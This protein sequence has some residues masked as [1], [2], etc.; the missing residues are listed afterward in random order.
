MSRSAIVN[1]AIRASA[2]TGKTYQLAMRYIRLL[3]ERCMPD[4]I[5]AMTFSRKAAAEI[6][7]A[8]VQNLR[9]AARDEEGANMIARDIG[10]DG[11]KPKDF[12]GLLRT[13]LD[14]LQLSHISTLDSFTVS[15]IRAFPMEL[16][17]STELN[18]MD[19]DGPA[20]RLVRFQVLSRVFNHRLTGERVQQNFHEAFKEA[21]F[22]RE[23]SDMFRHLDE[24]IRKYWNMFRALP[25]PSA[26]GNAQLIWPSGS[27]WLT[28][29]MKP[30]DAADQLRAIINSRSFQH[31]KIQPGLNQLVDGLAA[32]ELTRPWDQ[33]SAGHAALGQLL[34]IPDLATAGSAT[35][36]YHKEIKLNQKEC[37]LWA[38]L[39]EHFLGVELHR[40]LRETA[41]IAR[42][43]G[44]YR[45]LYE[46]LIR[47]GQMT[48][49]DAQYLLT[50]DNELSGNARVSRNPANRLYIDYRLNCRLD[51]W[52][53]DEFQ[54]T[55]DLQWEVVSNLI[56]EVMMDDSGR[57]RLFFVGDV[58]QAVHGWRGGNAR[59]FGKV[60]KTYE[61][62]IEEQNRIDSYRSCQD[63]LDMVNRVFHE[64]PDNVSA[65]V[66]DRWAGLWA[67]HRVAEGRAPKAGYGA[68]LQA[69][70][71][72]DKGKCLAED[73][74]RVVGQ[75]LKEI[76]PL[77]RGLSVVVLVRR[78]E[79]GKALVDQL[80]RECPNIPICHEGRARICDNPVVTVLL[81]LTKVAAHPGDTLAWQHLQMSPLRKYIQSEKLD[82]GKL[83]RLLLAE[84]Q[85]DGFES[86]I[87]RW[88][89]RLELAG[90]DH[91]GRK[92]VDDLAAAAA[93]FDQGD[94]RSCSDFLH[95]VMGHETEEAGTDA[96]VNVMTV[97]KSK[98]IGRDIVIAAD[99]ESKLHSTVDFALSRNRDMGSAAWA[100]KMPC[101]MVVEAD[102]TLHAAQTRKL[103]EME[104]EELC[105]LYVALTRA[106]RANY[107]VVGSD[108]PAGSL[109]AILKKQLCD[110]T[111]YAPWTFGDETVQCLY[112]TG[113]RNWHEREAVC[114]PKK[115]KQRPVLSMDFHKQDS[116][117]PHLTRREP[118]KL[119]APRRSAVSLFDREDTAVIDFGSAIHELFEKVQWAEDADVD[120]I[121]RA[122][123]PTSTC[124]KDV[125]R[126]AI[127]QFRACMKSD[128]VRKYLSR[129]AGRV[130]E[131]WIEKRFE[132][133][134]KGEL[135]AGAFD[136]VIVARDE[137]GR[138]VSA[139]ILD[140]KSSRVDEKAKIDRKVKEYKSQ[141]DTYR[142]ALARILNL[143]LSAITCCLIF[144]RQQEIRIPEVDKGH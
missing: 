44:E 65:D 91:F 6:L 12:L 15:V 19:N 121:V 98:G 63:V 56:S 13:L 21:T 3:A 58:K 9:K 36:K 137:H 69:T 133:I 32:S 135:V 119:H 136:R 35:I 109:S 81:S 55:S 52:L 51:H 77:R 141:M 105:V 45:A 129:P 114:R 37:R 59:L 61:G 26:W 30:A 73:R 99:L 31:A 86:A 64:L 144:T 79:A 42:I 80:R 41:G 40:R 8:I 138:V 28:P 20:A 39:I 71:T 143:K 100:L 24:F 66:R 22:G 7:D 117:R 93:V 126:D 102:D 16:G 34:E 89:A 33:K 107:A 48:F 4:Q 5:C 23:E 131:P 72:G 11:L 104:F 27:R 62:R 97:H 120:S 75:L 94:S 130:D 14:N 108:S 2:G 139:T 140:Y 84:I 29:S 74:Y 82:P 118:S 83:S 54:D 111:E 47:G 49:E 85:E 17:I 122:W 78:H 142:Q 128:A 50:S 110:N 57:K 125:T 123:E 95:F 88:G 113:E 132:V 43:L 60:L 115:E 134:L 96:S 124:D 112:E 46:R 68:L 25:D 76:D 90:D 92:R 106:K 101:K 1:E 103:E 87:R 127:E 38:V 116:L 53:L 10:K 70:P 18:L 67:N